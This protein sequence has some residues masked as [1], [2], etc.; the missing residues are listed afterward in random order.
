MRPRGFAVMLALTIA[1][2][3]AACGG[4]ASPAAPD[5]T[6]VPL[7]SSGDSVDIGNPSD[8]A[9]HALQGWGAISTDSAFPTEPGADRTARYQ[10]ARLS[11]SVELVVGAPAVPYTLVFRTQDGACDDSFDLYVNGAGPLYRYRHR[12][13]SELFPTHRVSIDASVVTTTTLKVT[14]MNVATDNCGFAAVYYVRAE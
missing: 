3:S 6:P 4:F 10:L 9:H 2:G 12:D 5:P 8:E 11:N 13:S 14:F 1:A 7:P